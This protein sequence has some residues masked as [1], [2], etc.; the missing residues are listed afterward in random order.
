MDV[1]PYLDR[2]SHKFHTCHSFKSIGHFN[3]YYVSMSAFMHVQNIPLPKWW[4][5]WWVLTIAR[6]WGGRK[7][8]V[9]PMKTPRTRSW[10][11]PTGYGGDSE[12]KRQDDIIM[13]PKLSVDNAESPTVSFASHFCFI[14]FFSRLWRASCTHFTFRKRSPL[15]SKSPRWIKNHNNN[16]NHNSKPSNT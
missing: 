14:V 11:K 10:H 16:N 7:S 12:V 5:W 15:L 2:Y 6:R 8:Q 1:C 4:W 3:G 9:P 13:L